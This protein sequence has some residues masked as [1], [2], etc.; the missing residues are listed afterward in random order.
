MDPIALL[1]LGGV[2][3]FDVAAL[4]P[5]LLFDATKRLLADRPTGNLVANH[6]LAATGYA[7]V[8]VLVAFA[9][10]IATGNVGFGWLAAATLGL[11]GSSWI[12]LAVVVPLLGWWDPGE[13]DGWDGRLA[14]GAVAVGYVGFVAAAV[15]FAA[16]GLLAVFARYP[17]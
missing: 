10:G 6:V 4:S 15:V 7:V 2:W 5:L 12:A 3:L 9:P 13:R 1:L 16:L 17:G 8:H 14:L 11:L